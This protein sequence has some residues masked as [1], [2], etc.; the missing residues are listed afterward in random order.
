MSQ[1]KFD[2]TIV[3]EAT[4]LIDEARTPLIISAQAEEAAD[5]YYQFA[6][7]VE[8]LVENEDY[9]VDEKMRAST[10]TAV[11]IKKMEDWLGLK[12]IY[13]EGGMATVHHVEA[14]LR[15]KAMFKRDRDYVIEQGRLLDE[16]TGR[17]AGPHYEGLHQAIG[18]R[19]RDSARK[20]WPQ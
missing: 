7:L 1:R 14:A 2:Y 3:D 9:N 20:P 16:F 15:A 17:N 18:L 10:L 13:A 6:K 4:L 12:N 5:K 19:G 11:G 8:R